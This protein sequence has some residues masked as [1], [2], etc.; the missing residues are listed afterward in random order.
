[1]LRVPPW[2][3]QDAPVLMYCRQCGGEIYE[4]IFL[5]E[6][7]LIFPGGLCRDCWKRRKEEDRD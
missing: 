2:D 6:D 7:E 3:R 5:D 4:N 1:M